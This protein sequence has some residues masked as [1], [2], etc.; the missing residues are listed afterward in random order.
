MSINPN[1]KEQDLDNLFCNFVEDINVKHSK[2]R[3]KLGRLTNP[4]GT[5]KSIKS[6]ESNKLPGLDS[7]P[8]DFYWHDISD[9]LLN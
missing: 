4:S 9:Y 5:S 6:T 7:T 3:R 8:A 1:I 2:R